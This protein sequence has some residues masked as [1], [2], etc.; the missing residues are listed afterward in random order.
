[1]QGQKV[2]FVDHLVQ[3]KRIGLVVVRPF[4]ETAHLGHRSP[5]QIAG[6]G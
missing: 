3:P 2:G 1:M 4:D 6:G 5:R